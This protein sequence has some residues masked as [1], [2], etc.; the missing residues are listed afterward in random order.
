MQESIVSVESSK[1][2]FDRVTSRLAERKLT[3]VDSHLFPVEETTTGE[4]RSAYI[5]ADPTLA[6]GSLNYALVDG[7]FRDACALRAVGLL[8]LGG[9]FILDNANWFIPHFTKSPDTVKRYRTQLWQEFAHRV[10][11]WRMIWTSNGVWDTAI[12]IKTT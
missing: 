5:N 11:D 8:K 12:W 1:E 3:N 7:L 10:A 9:V 4:A 6:A 2:W